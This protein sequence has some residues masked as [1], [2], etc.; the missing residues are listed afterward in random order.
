MMSGQ[1]NLLGVS[2]VV[3][4]Q[5]MGATGERFEKKFELSSQ[6]QGIVVAPGSDELLS[7]INSFLAQIKSDGTL[8]GIHQKWLGEPLPN[9]V[10]ENK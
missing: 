8:D 2:N 4:S 10:A 7:T 1:V 9:F 6:V 5:V 3:M